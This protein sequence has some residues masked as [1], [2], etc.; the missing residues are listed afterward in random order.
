M[1]KITDLRTKIAGVPITC[2]W[3]VGGAIGGIVLLIGIFTLGPLFYLNQ[4]M[5]TPT[6]DFNVIAKPTLTPTPTFTPTP[7]EESGPTLTPTLEPI[8]EG[9]FM[10]GQLVE[11]HG[12]E[13]EGLRV[14][15]APGIDGRI[16]FV[17]M[18]NE[19]FV[20]QGGPVEA[21]DH[22]WWYLVNPYDDDES[23]WS[24]AAYLQPLEAP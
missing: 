11:V 1:N 24:V 21:D 12:T 8:P 22:T 19:V 20:V 17:G 7:V 10:I 5:P 16:L 15:E 3:V 13:G 9:S 14:R 23:G 18:E 4:S 6:L 2:F